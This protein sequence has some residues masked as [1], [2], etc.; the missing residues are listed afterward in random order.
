MKRIKMFGIV[1]RDGSMEDG[2][3]AHA[4]RDFVGTFT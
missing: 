2:A 1:A 4:E 3:N